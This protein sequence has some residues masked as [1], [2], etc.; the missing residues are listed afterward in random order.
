M[1]RRH[2]QTTYFIE[3]EG[4][5][6]EERARGAAGRALAV[7]GDTAV[8]TELDTERAF[9][10]SRMFPSLAKFRP[11]IDA[12]IQLGQA[13]DDTPNFKDHH[14]LP[15][16]FTYFG[17][18]LDHDTTFDKTDGLPDTELNPEEIIQ[19]R[20][21]SLDLDNVYGRGPDLETKH[22]YEADGIHLRVGQT[23]GLG[24]SATD[25]ESLA[26][27]ND[28]PRGDNASAPRE[29]TIG[30][31][32]NDEN[33]VVAQTHLAF[34]KFH[35]VV[36]TRLAETG[37]SGSA[38]FEQ[39]R[40][41]VTLHYQWIVLHDFLPRVVEPTIL[42]GVING[43][44]RFFETTPDAE[45]TM[46]VEFSVAAY[47]FGHSMIRDEYN[48]NR[49]F[50]A[51]SL[52]L[53]FN[54]SGGSGDMLGF[55]TLPSNWPVDWRRMHD[56]S[57]VADIAPAPALNH[58]RSIDTGVAIP[59]K[60]LP[61]LNGEG[62]KAALAVR[63]LLRGRLIGL[64]TGQAVAEAIGVPVLT[65]AQVSQ[66][67]HAALVQQH[68]FDTQTPLWYYILKEA[69]V[70]NEGQRLGP[71]GSTLL[72]E[73]FVGLI[74]GSRYSVLAESNRYWRP[75]LPGVRPGQ[76]TLVDLL[77]L[78]GD[79]NPLGGERVQAPAPAPP[80]RTHIVQPG[81]TL[82][83]IAMRFLGDERRWRLIFEANRAQISNPDLIRPGMELI[84]PNV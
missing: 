66:G 31:P 8:E 76:F 78:V 11:D 44:R 56:F 35:N 63:N 58:T 45:P 67:P 71:V 15:A 61:G 69:E 51:A 28:L 46:P 55:P 80:Q 9:R 18:F 75:T 72:A 47:R 23:T 16:G 73:T 70:F 59:L 19:G 60:T 81:E 26:L 21:P 6:G 27:P 49:N 37:L 7:L 82:R 29:A 4:F 25:P 14:S 17:Q 79:L 62:H 39:A 48:W 64:P 74:E 32:R 3:G 33:L 83:S 34:L 68:G 5:V 36:A 24:G 42:A 13:M 84:I 20:S 52:G 22:L 57:H 53:L 50:P 40:R 43:G 54:F 77:L 41:A 10:F 1:S 2:G 30:D 65:A 12:L 38:L